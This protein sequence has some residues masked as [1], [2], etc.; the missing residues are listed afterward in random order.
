MRYLLLSAYDAASHQRWREGITRH[1]P[2]HDWTVLALPP[3]F[4][5]WRLNGNSLSWAFSEQ[6]TLSQDYDCVL[7][8]SMTDLSALRGLRPE[9]GQLPTVVYYHE[10]QFAYPIQKVYERDAFYFQRHNLYNALCA[11]VL[12]FNSSYN[13]NTFLKG[14]RDFL[15]KMPDQVPPGLLERIQERSQILPV[16]LE[17]DCFHN[18][19]ENEVTKPLSILWNHRWEYDKAPERFFH[20]LYAL[21]DAGYDFHLHV[22]GQQFRKSPK[23]F[24]EARQRLE[25]HIKT[26]GYLETKTAYQQLLRS[27]DLTIST[28][29]H[30]FQ[31]LALQEAVAAGCFP[32]APAR[33]SYQEFLPEHC[34]YASFTE[35]PERESQAL[36]QAIS[37][38]IERPERLKELPRPDLSPW[39][40][41]VMAPRYE[42]LLLETSKRRE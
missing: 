5:V 16:P 38:F 27:C 24:K 1:L 22:A 18:R 10:N 2:Q 8:T 15:K 20:A 6:E 33:L 34:L 14:V 23:I 4:F 39:S 31:G 25:K 40:W 9:L 26:W 3:R 35:E 32:L 30:E 17:A 41:E 11:D 42:D 12:A 36:F 37:E 19:P 13:R 21:S 7:A 29:L 28:A